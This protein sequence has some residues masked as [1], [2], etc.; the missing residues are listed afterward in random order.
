MPKKVLVTG[1]AGSLGSQALQALIAHGFAVVAAVRRDV[2]ELPA[3]AESV[4]FDFDDAKTFGPALSGVN[5]LFLIAPPLDPSSPRRLNPVID[6][7]KDANIE[8]VVFNSAIGINHNEHSPLRQVERHLMNSGLPYTILRPNFFMENFSKGHTASEIAQGGIYLAAG[9]AK[10]S[11]ISAADIAEAVA[12]AFERAENKAEYDLTGPE[13]LDHAEVAKIVTEATGRP[14]TYHAIEESAMIDGARQMGLPEPNLQYLAG[15]YGAVR[16]GFASPVKD[17]FH[18]LTG[19]Q[20]MTFR[21]FAETNSGAWAS[22][23]AG[24]V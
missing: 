24:R 9:D 16:N 4:R 23:S 12:V 7:A 10:T 2:D 11:F 14:V 15:L 18:R 6:A 1:A 13:A 3:G 22:T 8:F 21:E 17:D 5:L 19:K 20:P